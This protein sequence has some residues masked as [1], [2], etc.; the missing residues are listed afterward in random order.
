VG[1]Y[2]V[3]LVLVTTTTSVS[4]PTAVTSAATHT[5][6]VCIATS[7]TTIGTTATL[8]AKSMVSPAVVV[9]PSTPRSDSQEDAIVEIAVSVKALRGTGVRLVVV[10]AELTRRRNADFD[11]NAYFDA[12]ATT[13]PELNAD[14]HLGKGTS[15][16]Q[17]RAYN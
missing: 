17:H 2:A 9:A 14:A 10:I 4:T 1:G 6:L 11:R 16:E 7:V 12:Y 13:M 15:D 3:R 8:T 5:V